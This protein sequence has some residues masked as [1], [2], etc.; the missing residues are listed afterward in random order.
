MSS[1]GVFNSRHPRIRLKRAEHV[2]DDLRIVAIRRSSLAPLNRSPNIFAYETADDIDVAKT[3]NGGRC[4]RGENPN[5]RTMCRRG[6]NY[7]SESSI[8]ENT[9]FK[10]RRRNKK[11]LPLLRA[12]G[13]QRFVKIRRRAGNFFVV[14]LFLFTDRYRHSAE[15]SVEIRSVK[16]KTDDSRFS[17]GFFSLRLNDLL[18]GY[19][20]AYI[21]HTACTRNTLH[22]THTHVRVALSSRATRPIKAA[23]RV[24]SETSNF[25]RGNCAPHASRAPP[26]AHR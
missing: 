16:K 17:G 23:G 20:R 21:I 5:R 1:S 14:F 26:P 15:H 4:R 9:E 19:R 24:C 6:E 22:T 7:D 13:T 2:G 12:I 18:F 11:R 3:R 25:R 8:F 10:R